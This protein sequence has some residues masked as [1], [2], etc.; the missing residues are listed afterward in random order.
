MPFLPLRQKHSVVHTHPS[1]NSRPTEGA[2][3]DTFLRSDSISP[4]GFPAPVQR[5]RHLRWIFSKLQPVTEVQVPV[6]CDRIVQRTTDP[7]PWSLRSPSS[8]RLAHRYTP[9]FIPPVKTVSHGTAAGVTFGHDATGI[10]PS[11]AFS[12]SPSD[13][14]LA[15][16]VP[17]PS[18]R[19]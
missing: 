14:S 8:T 5:V 16:S 9:G 15:P 12:G 2:I 4:I 1:Q 18:A 10:P 3:S 7:R 19:P 17:R 13:D 11:E 6:V